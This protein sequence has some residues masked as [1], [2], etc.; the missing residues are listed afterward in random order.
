MRF[1][2]HFSLDSFMKSIKVVLFN[3]SKKEETDRLYTL[4]NYM[5]AGYN[6]AVTLFYQTQL[7]L[8]PSLYICTF[9]T[10]NIKVRAVLSQPC[11]P[12]TKL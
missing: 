9:Q 3:Y 1:S 12:G 10:E 5:T 6:P 11:K 8:N 4:C 7:L 2:L